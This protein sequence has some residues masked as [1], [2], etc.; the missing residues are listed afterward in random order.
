[1]VLSAITGFNEI[2][3]SSGSSRDKVLD[4]YGDFRNELLGLLDV[5]T[6]DEADLELDGIKI[7]ADM[8]NGAAGTYLINSWMSEQEFIFA[9]LMD[10]LKF[11]STLDKTINSVAANSA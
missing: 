10:A 1:M 4:F 6:D 11:E 8:K 3:I 5:L 2:N 7:D 9:Q